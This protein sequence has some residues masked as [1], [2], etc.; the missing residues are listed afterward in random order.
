MK[1]TQLYVNQVSKPTANLNQSV[2]DAQ[3]V[4]SNQRLDIPY[5]RLN[6]TPEN[7]L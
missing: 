4:G 3:S 1:Q 6:A 5:S 2:S 7:Y